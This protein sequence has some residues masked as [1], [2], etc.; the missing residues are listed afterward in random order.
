MPVVDLLV[1]GSNPVYDVLLGLAAWILLAPYGEAATFLLHADARARFEGLDLWYRVR[2]LFP[3]LH[4]SRAGLILL[5]LGAT[6]APAAGLHADTSLET[7]RGVRQQVVAV[8]EEMNTAHPYPGAQVWLPRLQRLADLLD[9]DGS[10][11]RGRY[12][13]FR[14][15]VAGLPHRRQED[16]VAVLGNLE[17]QLALVEQAL[18]AEASEATPGEQP[19]LSREAIKALVPPEQG[20]ERYQ[21]PPPPNAETEEPQ[22]TREPPGDF[23]DQVGPR[24]VERR[25]PGLVGASPAGG[26]AT[27]GWLLLAGLLA[28][29]LVIG[30]IRFLRNRKKARA[31]AQAPKIERAELPPESLLEQPTQQTATSLWR[32]ADRLAE[33]GNLPEAIRT[34]H[35]AVLALLHWAGL[36][37][38]E[39]TRTNGEYE[40]QL[41]SRPELLPPFRRLTGLVECKWYGEQACQPGDYRACRGMAETIRGE[42]DQ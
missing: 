1:S 35:L 5:T 33:G 30:T 28:A 36:I 15:A 16:A 26:F 17:R 7:V 32:Q 31:L 12:R 21:R 14:Q 4:K 41:R 24:R 8:K 22:Q 9:P 37:R 10:T 2:R 11:T 27:V 3:A 18:A 6:L 20:P 19:A 40:A 25:G 23:G 38:Y 13:W 42:V 39:R 29:V 34:L